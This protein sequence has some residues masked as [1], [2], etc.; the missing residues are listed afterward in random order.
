[1]EG[2]EVTGEEVEEEQEVEPEVEGEDP[3]AVKETTEEVAEGKHTLESVT[4][5]TAG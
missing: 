1:V 3:N 4:C 2:E 5:H